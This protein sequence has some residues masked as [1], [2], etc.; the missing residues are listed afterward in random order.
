[1]DTHHKLR[2]SLLTPSCL[3]LKKCNDKNKKKN[4]FILLNHDEI[5]Q[6]LEGESKIDFFFLILL[7]KFSDFLFF[8]KTK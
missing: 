2:R 8:L 5:K 7:F 1:M 6:N 3:N 4:K